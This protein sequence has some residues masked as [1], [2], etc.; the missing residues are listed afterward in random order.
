MIQT[1]H[2]SYPVERTLLTTGILDA[3]MTSRAEKGRVVN[4]PH[5]AIRYRAADWPFASDPIPKP[6]QR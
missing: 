2:A 1:G 4:T 3:M 5:L 6:V